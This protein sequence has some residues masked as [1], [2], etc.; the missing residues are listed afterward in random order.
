MIIKNEVNLQEKYNKISK[1][2]RGYYIENNMLFFEHDIIEYILK[3]GKIIY[4][5][6]MDR[7]NIKNVNH[8]ILVTFSKN[9]I[10]IK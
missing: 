2:E 8:L 5:F 10:K 9:I 7:T 1:E 4:T 3:D 6:G